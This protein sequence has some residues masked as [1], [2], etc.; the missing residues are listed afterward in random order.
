M[1]G[2]GLPARHLRQA[3]GGTARGG[4]QGHIQ[5]HAVKERHDATDG[6]GLAGAGA[7]GEQHHAPLR[8]QGHGLALGGGIGDARLALQLVDDPLRAA[9]GVGTVVGHGQQP[10]GHRRLR[11]VE[12]PK[13]AARHL[14]YG[15]LADSVAVQHTVQRRLHRV[16]VH[17][18]QCGGGGK[19]LLPGQEHV[20]VAQIVGQLVG[21]GRLQAAG[22]LAAYAQ[23]D[24]DFIGSGKSHAEPLI[25]Q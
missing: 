15:A 9:E 2:L 22:V 1:D 18:H 16:A 6:G 23:S 8:R 11:L 4:Q 17:V 14:A 21:K 24:G 25:H 5:A 12:G 13:I 10:L 19:Q 3:L 7:A 20:T